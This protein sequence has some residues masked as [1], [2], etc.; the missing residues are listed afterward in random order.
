MS[1]MLETVS[2][3]KQQLEKRVSNLENESKEKYEVASMVSTGY[4]EVLN[5]KLEEAKK[6]GETLR[7]ELDSSYGENR[8]HQ[9]RRRMVGHQDQQVLT[10]GDCSQTLL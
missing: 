1:S 3:S 7:G 2:L 6:E 4:R 8:S 9:D 5:K 10:E